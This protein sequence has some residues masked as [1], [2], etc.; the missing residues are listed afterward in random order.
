MLPY[1]TKS[2]FQVTNSINVTIVH[3]STTLNI[4]FPFFASSFSFCYIGFEPF[5]A[6]SGTFAKSRKY[7][8]EPFNLEFTVGIFVI[9]QVSDIQL[10]IEIQD[11][12]K[13]Y[14]F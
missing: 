2:S 11:R 7:G 13:Q 3:S 5:F 1:Q 10:N 9:Y 8:F 4:C 6:S 14:V 12:V